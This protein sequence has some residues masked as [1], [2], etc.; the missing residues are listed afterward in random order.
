[1]WT[2]G[3]LWALGAT[4][5]KRMRMFYST[6]LASEPRVDYVDELCNLGFGRLCARVLF[7]FIYYFIAWYSDLNLIH[8]LI[9]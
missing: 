5:W 3:R 1:M 7:S 6:G 2:C 8:V 4:D 9:K